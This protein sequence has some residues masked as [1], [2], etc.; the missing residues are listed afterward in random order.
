MK[1]FSIYLSAIAFVFLPVNATV[2]AQQNKDDVFGYFFMTGRVPAAF[3]DIDHL[4]LDGDYGRSQKPPT[5]GRIRLKNKARTDYNLL[6]P[7]ISGRNLS[8]KTKAVRG[9]SYEF[10]GILTGTDFG[11]DPKPAPEEI[12]LRGMLKKMRGGKAVAENR[13]RFR[14]EPGD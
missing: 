11:K 8:F 1:T 10:A 2:F 5:Y 14:W 7:T 3:K 4:S 9:T 13:V 12:V 6:R